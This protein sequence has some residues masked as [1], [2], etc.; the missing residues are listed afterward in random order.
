MQPEM[1]IIFDERRRALRLA[2]AR[3]RQGARWLVEVMAEEIVERLGFLRFEAASALVSGLGGELVAGALGPARV[4][5]C[6]SLPFGQTLL[7]GPWGLIVSLGE[8]DT[9]NDLPGALIQLRHALEP[10]GLLLAVM[11]G[12]GSLPRLR[13][14]MLA[15]DGDRP[16]ARIHPQIDGRAA[17]ALLQRAGF[18]RHVVDSHG[19][20]ARYPGLRPLVDE[21][22]DQGLTSVLADRG[23]PLGKATLRRAEAAFAAAADGDGKT[24]ERFEL[25]TLTAW[26]D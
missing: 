2:R 16:A 23:P 9:V 15:A 25:V 8:L 20:D 21:L 17:S 19:I 6:D 14:A 5:L 18:A 22:R 26:K 4:V 10:G 1:P 3:R 24:S 7:G 11:P 12:A 13:G